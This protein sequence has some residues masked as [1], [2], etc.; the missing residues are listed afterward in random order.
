MFC[1]VARM[2]WSKSCRKEPLGDDQTWVL[3]PGCTGWETMAS[4]MKDSDESTL[5][6]IANTCRKYPSASLWGTPVRL[7]QQLMEKNDMSCRVVRTYCGGDK[8]PLTIKATFLLYLEVALP[9]S[10]EGVLKIWSRWGQ[11]RGAWSDLVMRNINTRAVQI[12]LVMECV[13]RGGD[14][15][16]WASLNSSSVGGGRH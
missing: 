10:V 7:S 15:G 3:G 14:H 13:W 1:F 6:W 11:S 9:R 4:S 8:M 16:Y 2:G 12:N 5:G